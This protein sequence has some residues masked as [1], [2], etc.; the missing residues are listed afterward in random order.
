MG[1]SSPNAMIIVDSKDDFEHNSTEQNEMN[2][3]TEQNFYSFGNL[4]F[5]TISYVEDHRQLIELN[6][7]NIPYIQNDHNRYIFRDLLTSDNGLNDPSGSSKSTSQAIYLLERIMNIFVLRLITPNFTI[8]KNDF[9]NIIQF[10]KRYIIGEVR[11]QRSSDTVDPDFLN[12]LRIILEVYIPSTCDATINDLFGEDNIPFEYQLDVTT[13][14]FSEPL[15][16]STKY[17]FNINF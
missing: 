4:T 5:L 1:S 15:N 17:I 7:N 13:T 10:I 16:E 3:N 11:S 14:F 12:R 8:F 2:G 6:D 9:I